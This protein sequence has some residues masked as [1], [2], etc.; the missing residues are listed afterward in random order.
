VVIKIIEIMKRT[1]RLFVA[2]ILLT[3][4]VLFAQYGTLDNSFNRD[5]KV[6]TAFGNYDSSVNSLAL[7]PDGKIIAAGAVFNHVFNQF[8]ITRYNIDGSLDATFGINGK[9]VGDFLDSKMSLKTIILQ[10]DGKIIGGGINYTNSQFVL[11][12]Y[13]SNGTLD[14]DFGVGGIITR[15]SVNIGSLVLQPDGKII[16]AGFLL[17]GYNRQFVLIRYNNDGTLDSDFGS[18]GIATTSIGAKDLGYDVVLHS[19]GKIVLSGASHNTSGE[20]NSDFAIIRFNK[21]GVLDPTF[22]TDGIVI[23]DIDDIDEARSVKVQ[24]DEK[25][26]FA[27]WS[28]SS[29]GS[30]SSFKLIR[31]LP[32]GS[33]DTEF[34]N[35]GMVTT[36]ISLGASS[37]SIEIQTDGKIVVAGSYPKSGGSDIALERHSANGDLDVTFGEN[38]YVITPFSTTSKANSLVLQSDGRIVVGG[39]AGTT[40]GGY[41]SD[42]AVLEYHSGLVLSNAEFN[43]L[44]NAFSVYPNPVNQTVNLDF[45]LNQAEELSV[46]LYDIN[47][48]KVANLLKEKSFQTGHH[49]QRLELPGTLSKG[50]Y[51]LY[52]SN[53][54]NTSNV[55]IVK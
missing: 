20:Y 44:E 54:R 45:N 5:G 10:T 12:R 8:G 26:V 50:I 3:S 31:L 53:G 38:G 33:F 24:D 9:V 49:S 51:F 7:Q 23:I 6:L 28:Y 14:T 52:I 21:D 17:E 15:D 43:S 37:E 30:P 32:D 47:G 36:I 25:I 35:N 18:N 22:G 48:I 39:E 42:F 27:G 4:K 34:G 19:N 11:V 16:A 1:I 2:I 55:K 13:N 46:N 40:V 41:N 29:S